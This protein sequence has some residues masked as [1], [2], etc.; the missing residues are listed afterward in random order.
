MCGEA[1]K[2]HDPIPQRRS[3]GTDRHKPL[4]FAPAIRRAERNAQIDLAP[5]DRD[6]RRG[7]EG[8]AEPGHK[9]PAKYAIDNYLQ[10]MK[11]WFMVPD[12]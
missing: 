12:S 6:D 7:T 10:N 4:D 3:G 9:I 1:I 5:G 2:G 8:K 11:V